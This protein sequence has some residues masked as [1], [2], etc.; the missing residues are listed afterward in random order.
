MWIV[1]RQED[2]FAGP[3]LE[4]LSAPILD[5]DMKLALDDIVIKNQVG[6][7]PKGRAA[8]LWLT[9][10]D[11]HHGAKKSAC[12]NTPPVKCATLKTS[13]SASIPPSYQDPV[14]RSCLPAGRS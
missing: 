7:W 13:D 5:L 12:R 10:A 11:M 8:M 1:A 4:A 9:R 14:F 6:R 2:D 3:Y